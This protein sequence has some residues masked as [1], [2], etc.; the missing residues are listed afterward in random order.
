MSSFLYEGPESAQEKPDN[1][2]N[3][4][5]FFDTAVGQGMPPLILFLRKRPNM[6]TLNGYTFYY[7][8]FQP[9]RLLSISNFKTFTSFCND[10]EGKVFD[11][12]RKRAVERHGS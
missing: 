10:G 4:D 5:S 6:P 2:S 8:S 9:Q 12:R 3:A 11:K 1:S 7:F